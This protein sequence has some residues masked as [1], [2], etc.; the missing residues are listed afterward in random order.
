MSKP[1]TAMSRRSLLKGALVL[2]FALPVTKRLRAANLAPGAIAAGPAGKVLAPNGFIHIDGGGTTF[3]IPN[4]EMG[5]GIYTAEAMLIAEEL[6]IGLNQIR[7]E[8]APPNAEIYMT[9]LL[10]FQGT[11]GSTSIRSWW[12]PLRKAGATARLL[13]ITAAANRWQVNPE[14]CQAVDGSV[15]HPASGRSLAYTELA[16]DASTLAVPADVPLKNPADFKLVGNSAKRVDM[17]GKVDGTAVFGIDVRV[18]GMKVAS[19]IASP[20]FGGKLKS[21]DNSAAAA[22][23]GFIRVITIE[24]AVAAVAENTWAAQRAAAALQIVWDDGANVNVTTAS[25]R[26]ELAAASKDG[27]PIVALDEGDAMDALSKDTNR[28]DATYELPFLAHATMEP[29]NTIVHVQADGCDIWC[30]TQVPAT[31]VL[32]AAQATGLPAEKIRLHNQLIGGGFGRRLEADSIAQAAAFANQ[33][34]YPLQVFWSREEDIRQDYYRPAYHDRLSAALGTDGLPIAMWHRTTG[35]SVLARFAPS[36]MLP[37]GLDSDVVEGSVEIPYDIPKRKVEW[38]R[39][40]PPKGLPFSWWRGVGPAHNVFVIETFIDELAH[41]ASEDPIKYRARMLEHNPRALAVLKLAAEQSGWGQPL[42]ERHGRGVS[43]HQAFGSFCALVVEVAVWPE[44]IIR[45]TK[46][47][48]AIDCG[49][50]VNP[51]TMVAQIEGGTLFGL[52]AALFSGIEF[53][54]GKTVQSNFHDY[55]VMRIDEAPRVEVHHIQSA[56]SPGGIGEVGTASAFPAL[57]NALFA[58]T[59]VRLRKTPFD[60]TQLISRSSDKPILSGLAAGTKRSGDVK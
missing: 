37:S 20:V 11:G 31:A 53:E 45:L 56:E 60:Q 59:G 47:T 58:A 35:G 38:V 2:G 1:R 10:H 46:A 39:H 42:P 49:F 52:S 33:V 7:I 18:P 17:P 23:P 14:A 41:K 40:D 57:G 28:I 51:D 5:Q 32:L 13:L 8:A 6:E 3:I 34:E 25:I 16:A 21:V 9:P 48:A 36:A 12:E 29:I 54:G 27:E 50:T 15:V 26:R 55:R 19:V 44:G 22:V 30:G 24:N 43:L 4:V